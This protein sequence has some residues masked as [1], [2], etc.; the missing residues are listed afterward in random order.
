MPCTNFGWVGCCCRKVPISVSSIHPLSFYNDYLLW[1]EVKEQKVSAVFRAACVYFWHTCAKQSEIKEEISTGRIIALPKPVCNQSGEN[2][3]VCTLD[4]EWSY[5]ENV[6]VK[7]RVLHRYVKSMVCIST[8]SHLSFRKVFP[9]SLA[10]FFQLCAPHQSKRMEACVCV[11]HENRPKI[12]ITSL[13][14]I[15]L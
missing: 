10:H 8:V 12:I 4:V 15:L 6:F 14:L 11:P 3:C 7:S 1:L 2:A 13:S 9:P 5:S